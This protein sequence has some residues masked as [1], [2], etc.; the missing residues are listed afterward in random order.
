MLDT[1][2]P[3]VYF[4]APR[5]I[6][7]RDVPLAKPLGDHLLVRTHVSAI[8]AGT[9]LLFYRNL[10]PADM[11]VDSAFEGMSGRLAYPLHYGY[12][13]AGEVTAVGPQGDAGWLGRNVFA[14]HPHAGGFTIAPDSVVSLPPGMNY[15]RAAFLPNVETSVGLVMDAA[16]LIGERVLVFG[17]GV[18][19]LLVTSLL[20]QMPLQRIVTVDQIDRRRQISQELG[21]TASV[22]PNE[23]GELERLE[24]DII[25][26]VS[27][28]PQALDA[29]IR[30]APY[31]ARIV[32]GSWYG[33][34]PAH[35]ALGGHFHRNHVTIVSSQ[36]S[37]IA[38]ALTGR[39]SKR[40][41]LSTALSHLARLDTSALVSHRIEVEH[42]AEAFRILDESP[43][44][45]LQ[46]LLTY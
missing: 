14:F 43:D 40:R 15:E 24:P 22:A 46:I 39:W 28:N 30:I 17:Q 32:V 5:Q 27:G 8:S 45:A 13:C 25:F 20:A 21:A 42:A 37:T 11:S 7:V 44:T 36:V 38:P 41:R 34:K 31:G 4:S 2:T 12:A 26:E 6:E 10:V 1:T 9:E 33:A 16:P 18:V 23:L 29:A 35:L 19:G 3:A